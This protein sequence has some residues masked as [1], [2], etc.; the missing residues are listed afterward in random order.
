[1]IENSFNR[2]DF[3]KVMGW[4]GAT[5]ALSG[6]GNTSVEDGR[7]FVT[8]YVQTA[9]YIIPSIGTY[10]NSTCAQCDAGCGI[11]GRVR[12]G[13]V[14]KLEGNPKAPVNSGKMCGLG[15]AGVQAHYNPDRIREPLL[16]NG[17]RGEAISWEKALQ[18][19]NE[20][21]AGTQPE[22]IA[23]LTGGV[24][25][26]V[27]VL[28]KNYLD[29]LGSG[30]HYVYEAV[31]PSVSRAAN[32][33]AYGVEMPR[34]N[35]EK[36]KVILSFGADF[37]G[38]WVS[39]VHFSQQ[40]ARF[41]K[42]ANGERGVLVQVESKMTLTGANADRWL[43]IRPGTEGILALGLINALAAAGVA[44][45]G[46][47][48]AVVKDYT[49]DRVS[50]DTGIS[51]EHMGKLT[52]LLKDRSPSLIIAGSAAEGYAHGSQN[53]AAI[54]LL[55]QVLGNVGKTVEAPSDMPFPQ[56]APT[57]GNRSSLQALNDNIVQD[58][59]KV[60]F[61]YGANPVYTAPASMNLKEN[62]KKVP[63][64]VVFARYM[65]ETAVE[66][67]LVLPLNSALE[68]WGTAV[69]EYFTDSAQLNIQQPL[70]EK[71][72]PGTLGMGDILL[73]LLKQ[74]RPNEYNGYE[75]FYSYL[76]N[77]LVTIRGALGGG[78]ED[79]NVF[80]DSA[81]SQGVLKLA[82]APNN[83]AGNASAAGLTLP[84]P[85][86]EDNAYPLRLI[87]AI[88]PNMRDGRHANEPWLQESPDPLTT[89]VWDSW[90]EMHPKTAAK[91]G[92]VEGDI[93][94]IASKSGAIKGQVYVF[95]GIHPDVI[96]VPLGYGH[97]AMGRYSKGVGA[98]AFK[99]L[100]PVFDQQTGE[101][102]MHETR[103]KITKAGQR[104]II[105]KDEGPAKGNQSGR[106]IALRVA[107]GKVNLAEEV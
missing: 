72:H 76:R 25:G 90:V 65:D 46:D 18:L 103:V 32:K 79:E 71:L 16:R 101:L 95:S 54:A 22:S 84:P 98:N 104:V 59:V 75:D 9:D 52:A 82:G 58:K 31:S 69:P 24:S 73:A 53:A 42:G 100:D 67:D 36:A 86:A 44:V 78:S 41:R 62:L 61:S 64:K 19:V 88:T 105:V 63:F 66:A 87:P 102:A 49:P 27:K 45:S 11:M 94:E 83:I 5:V 29:A 43:A 55:N 96:S 97:E 39:P 56:M 1:M 92:V 80:W 37:L 51:I 28:L 35:M 13:R 81:L 6:C 2:R 3:L 107:S 20:K 26:H 50:N 40:Y 70:M 74:R 99:I 15:Q 48:A 85:A 68:D 23:F 17:D 34:L 33:K 10:F 30:H 47:V 38:A 12:E 60:L 21:V 14:L 77:A 93:V 89:I 8:S 7:E 4:G 106:R 57:S 91:L